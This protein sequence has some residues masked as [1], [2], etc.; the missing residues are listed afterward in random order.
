MQAAQTEGVVERLGRSEAMFVR[1]K[2][3]RLIRPL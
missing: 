1:F 3:C 2:P